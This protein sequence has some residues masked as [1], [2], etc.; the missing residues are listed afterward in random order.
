MIETLGDYKRTHNCGE[1]RKEHI[2]DEV[3]LMGWVNRSRD[4]GGVIFVDLRD[5]WGITQVVFDPTVDA[6]L[7][8]LGERM[9]SEFVIAVHGKVR[10]RPAGNENPSLP[11]GEVEVLVSEA[12]ILNTSE[13]PPIYVSDEGDED[14]RIRLRYRYLDLRRT[15]MQRN[16]IFRSR[17]SKTV[18]DYMSENDF[19]EIDT[20]VLSK[21]TPEGARDFL[22]PSR[23]LP[24]TFYA[25]PQSPQLFKQ[26]LMAS[27]YEKYFQ[28]VKCY[29]DEDLRAD[30][31]PEHT[32]I[33]LEMSFIT[34]EN[35]YS[36]IEGLIKKVF[37]EGLDI[38]IATP[39]PRL[40]YKESL[41]RYGTDKPD[42][43]YELQITDVT[44][45][46]RGSDFKIFETLIQGGGIVRGFTITGG[47]AFSRK[48]LDDLIAYSQ[49]LGSSGLAW[50]RLKG[51]QTDS[52][53]AKFFAEQQLQA[54]RTTMNAKDGDL[55]AFLAGQEK[56]IVP[57][58]G[59]LRLHLIEKT[60]MQ[61]KQPYA[62]TWV[63]DFPLFE[64]DTERKGWA[65]M[66][67][68]FTMPREQDIPL[69]DSAPGEVM[70]RLYD[71]VLNGTEL[72]SGSIRIHI[73][74][75]QE[76]VFSI[77]GLEQEAAR[78]RF[79]FLLDAFQY[80]APPHGGIALGL[81]RLLMLMLGEN[82]IREVI[83]FPKTQ[84]G[85]CLMTGAPSPV[86]KDQLREVGIRLLEP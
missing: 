81:D 54:L 20:P 22:V 59:E 68:I 26:I 9:R 56:A 70:G 75:L 12:K 83:P 48:E 55:L 74:E 63:T 15:R 3:C 43:R 80:G 60:K 24:G 44:D 50:M 21:S 69:L 35:I 13:T 11:T 65:P 18:R 28:I 45:V 34:E 5:R 71:L 32:Q 25:L 36:L 33:D 67:H 47:A 41:L 76:K 16:L 66:H 30:R 4:H 79:G 46:M 2:G 10:L 8:A 82:S 73:R 29:R 64:W 40:T 84:S 61:P 17:I 58:L 14:E 19:L 77:I 78:E 39:L 49:K 38:D 51:D 31:Q 7:F 85:A 42:L 23:L 57:I 1:L 86:E 52:P 37:K 27:G 72:G 6:N 62:F 53:I